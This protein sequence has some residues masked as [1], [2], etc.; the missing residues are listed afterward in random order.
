M[1]LI[2]ETNFSNR[3]WGCPVYFR[4]TLIIV[5]FSVFKELPSHFCH[6]IM[7]GSFMAPHPKCGLV[8]HE[9]CPCQVKGS[10]RSVMKVTGSRLEILEFERFCHKCMQVYWR[11]IHQYLAHVLLVQSHMS[12]YPA[13]AVHTWSHCW[14]TTISAFYFFSL[15][16]HQMQVLSPSL[17]CPIVPVFSF[18]F[19]FLLTCFWESHLFLGLQLMCLCVCLG[20]LCGVWLAHFP[21]ISH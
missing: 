7:E 6:L 16:F 2:L 12:H 9:K 21:S 5:V 18:S 20:A 10:S 4:S 19:S 1:V 17:V 14:R 11:V 3:F 15:L 13:A 8:P